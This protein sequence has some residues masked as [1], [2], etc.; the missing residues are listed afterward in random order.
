M[1]GR[2][3]K[4]ISGNSTFAVEIDETHTV[5]DFK[6][7]IETK[8]TPELDAL[9]ADAFT[10]YKINISISDDDNYTTIMNAI[11]QGDYGFGNKQKPNPSCEV[12]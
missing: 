3:I 6:E 1:S 2:W 11:S 7:K 8:M 5:G 10:F 4:L 9:A 12:I